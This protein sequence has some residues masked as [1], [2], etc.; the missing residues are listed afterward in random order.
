VL[1]DCAGLIS[2]T[3]NI[4]DELAQQAAIEAL[5]NSS[6]VL[7][8]ADIA[9]ADRR[10]DTSIRTLVEPRV[11][12]SDLLS[13]E[14]LSNRVGELNELF[15]TEFLATS[16]ET[17][18][19]IELLR[20]TIDRKI[21]ELTVGAVSGGQVPEQISSVALTTRHRQAVTEAIE[22]VIEATSE[23]KEGNDEVTSMILRAAYRG[24][25]D[26]ESA[27]SGPDRADEQILEMIFS[28]FCIGK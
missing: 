5:R 9:K 18:R 17:G 13:E 2:A 27:T 4:L 26:I 8:C 14:I 3:N 19:G 12:K 7:F 22:N 6:V 28:R 23:L 10:E 25:Y 11:L 24:L 20:K 21:L 1:F 16:A 15:G